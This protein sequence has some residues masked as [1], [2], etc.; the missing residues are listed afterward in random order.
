MAIPS[1]W[2]QDLET[3][4]TTEKQAAAPTPPATG[5]R[6]YTGFCSRIKDAPLESAAHD[7]LSVAR[8]PLLSRFAR[9][10]DEQFRNA[11]INLCDNGSFILD[12]RKGGKC[13]STIDLGSDRIDVIKRL[14]LIKPDVTMVWL[15]CVRADQPFA[16]FRLK[17]AMLLIEQS[18]F[19]ELGLF[20]CE[21]STGISIADSNFRDGLEVDGIKA[22]MD[23]QIR[24]TRFGRYRAPG[25]RGRWIANNYAL[26][27]KRTKIEGDLSIEQ[28]TFRGFVTIDGNEVGGSIRIL[29]SQLYKTTRI[30][31]NSVA[32]ET[33]IGED[34]GTNVVFY[35]QLIASQCK[36]G[37]FEIKRVAFHRA[38]LARDCQVERGFRFSSVK[39]NGIYLSRTRAGNIGFT[40]TDSTD[41]VVL[42]DV[43]ANHIFF[44][45]GSVR[46]TLFAGNVQTNWFQ[47]N[48]TA[49]PTFDCTDCMIDQY[50][51]LNG[52]FSDQVRLGNA[53]IRS[54]RFREGE[55]HVT[56]GDH[57]IL[58]LH[59]AEIVSLAADDCDLV[60]TSSPPPDCPGEFV[61]TLLHG[62][63]M[64]RIDP[65]NRG[66]GEA[67]LSIL[68]R[69]SKS[70]ID[71]IQ[72]SAR[73]Q[74]VNAIP[75]PGAADAVSYSDPEQAGS[76]NVDPVTKP[77]ATRGAGLPFDPTPYQAV[78]GA[79][80]RAGYDEKA[81]DIRIAKV[82]EEVK[83]YSF[84][85]WILLS[86][87]RGLTGYGYHNEWSVYWFLLLVG[88]GWWVYLAGHNPEV[89]Q[90][91][92]P[93]LQLGYPAWF[94]LDRAIPQLNLDPTMHRYTML[95]PWA[96]YYY[97][98]HRLFGSVIIA[99]A[100]AGLT[101]VFQ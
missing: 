15:A 66:P 21:F 69:P 42:E 96:R 68:D 67:G 39:A 37:T 10:D 99:F 19:A 30:E 65:G 90:F 70:I 84:F 76:G 40:N 27:L 62:T 46:P 60:V 29:N 91:K 92:Q 12:G 32:K 82:D 79:L 98:V 43:I 88:V 86:I 48:S 6:V 83:S 54:L 63:R 78:A 11:L 71:W 23:F 41:E 59:G 52:E 44:N 49:V 4:P 20:T 77:N 24:S 36:T 101:G 61:K 89:G 95:R 9:P 28:S 35:G 45:Q 100:I 14:S 80:D 2:A 34:T 93:A 55:N 58:D 81:K 64:D 16:L 97:Y 72:S 31:K 38:L 1:A 5:L 7:P 3:N 53:K 22:G 87:G 51:A 75:Q 26:R 94:S 25:L 74:P 13:D 57:A 73:H 18:R 17:G 33:L 56:W 50:L 8:D 85:P 47:I